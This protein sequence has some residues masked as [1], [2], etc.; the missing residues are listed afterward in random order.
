MK[1]EHSKLKEEY[2]LVNGHYQKLYDEAQHLMYTLQRKEHDMEYYRE[3]TAKREAG[4]TPALFDI[5][6]WSL[7]FGGA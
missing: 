1:R 2:D 3:R 6:F 7:F 4:N 5:H